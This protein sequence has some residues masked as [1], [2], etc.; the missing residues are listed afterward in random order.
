M[1]DPIEGGVDTP[2]DE[3]KDTPDIAAT[4]AAAIEAALAPALAPL[5]EDVESIRRNKLDTRNK[6][7]NDEIA[8]RDNMIA[9]LKS[10]VES[11]SPETAETKDALVQ[12]FRDDLANQV[13]KMAD[14][15]AKFAAAQ[16]K[17]RRKELEDLVLADVAPAHREVAL[18]LMEGTLHRQQIN[19]DETDDLASLVEPLKKKIASTLSVPEVQSGN[20]NPSDN[21]PGAPI[22]PDKISWLRPDGTP[23]FR[24]YASIPEEI[25]HLL[26]QDVFQ[27]MV[28]PGQKDFGGLNL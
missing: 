4:V 7:L 10:K 1:T 25:R 24:D 22:D 2:A 17:L 9:E 3:G 6:K 21:V 12:R 18:D 11:L 20:A 28:K 19:I 26:P 8:A 15:E 23:T 5:R 14:V 27:K 16:S 13:K